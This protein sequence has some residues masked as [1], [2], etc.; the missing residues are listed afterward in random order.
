MRIIGEFDAGDIKVSVF[1][2]NE[3]IS[4]K[5]EKHLMEQT[6][7]FRDGSAVNT[8]EDAKI[9][10]SEQTIDEINK[11]FLA[12]ANTRSNSLNSMMAA[13]EDEFDEII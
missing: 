4:I 3:R 6:Y 12:M 2:M 7:K 1:K 5:F 11:V 10:C 13:E 8:L 9:F